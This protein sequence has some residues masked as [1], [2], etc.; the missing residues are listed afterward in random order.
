MRNKINTPNKETL[1]MRKWRENNRERDAENKKRQYYT[2][3]EKSKEY[4]RNWKKENYKTYRISQ[5][6]SRDKL[7]VQVLSKYSK[8][9]FPECVCCGETVLE[10][11]T[12]DHINNDGHK[13]SMD[14]R[15]AIY[16][17]LKRNNYPDGFQTLCMNCQFGKRIN[18]GICPHK[19][20]NNNLLNS[21]NTILKAV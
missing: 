13:Q 1:R 2:N 14:E 17:W 12:I 6:L 15:K 20:E 9:N 18:N 4:F 3:H 10:F 21:V 5:R 7:K 11:L 16:Y 19:K 8:N